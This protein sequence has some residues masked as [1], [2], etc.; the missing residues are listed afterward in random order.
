M[1]SVAMAHRWY[2]PWGI[3]V[4]RDA[5]CG[6]RACDLFAGHPQQR[7]QLAVIDPLIAAGDHQN[8]SV[9]YHKAQALRDLSDLAADGLGSQWR[10]RGRMQEQSDGDAEVKGIQGRLHVVRGECFHSDRPL[11]TA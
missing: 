6:R 1:R 4:I 2:A 3:A 9:M 7:R 11:A 10:R 5:L 8:R